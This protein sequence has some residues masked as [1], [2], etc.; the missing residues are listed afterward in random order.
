LWYGVSQALASAVMS[1]T[2]HWYQAGFYVGS[3]VS[4]SKADDQK[5]RKIFMLAFIRALLLEWDL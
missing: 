2:P 3:K 5:L 4:G 1:I